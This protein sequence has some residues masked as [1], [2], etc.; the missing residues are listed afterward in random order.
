MWPDVPSRL[1][2]PLL[3][4]RTAGERAECHPGEPFTGN[5]AV[6]AE[7]TNPLSL[8]RMFRSGDNIVLR[9]GRQGV[10]ERR[11]TGDA[12]HQIPILI[13]VFFGL[14]QEFTRH[15]IVLNMSALMRLKEGAQE[16]EQLLAV[17]VVIQGCRVELLV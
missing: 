13:R 8:Q 12:Y 11:V 4:K 9:F 14:L 6:I 7:N 15:D 3:C 16:E 1:R 10:K 5:S 17:A 2:S